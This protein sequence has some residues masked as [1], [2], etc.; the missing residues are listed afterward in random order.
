[1]AGGWWDH[2]AVRD[3]SGSAEDRLDNLLTFQGLL[4]QVARDLGPA[5]ELHP[6]LTTVLNAMRSL[7]K[8]R[9]GTIGLVDERG[10][11]VAAS[12]PPVSPDV[13]AARVPVGSGLAGRCVERGEPVYSPDI[14]VDERVDPELRRVGS[15]RDMRSYL[16]VPLVCLGE[17]IGVLQVDSEEPDAFDA[18]DRRVLEGLAT[19]VAGAIEG[20]RRFE[21]IRR[22]DA[23]RAMFIARVSHELRTPLTILRGF[24]GTL[25]RNAAEYHLNDV[26]VSLVAR[27]DSAG[28]RLQGLVEELL[29]VSRVASGDMAPEPR[30]V[31]LRGELEQ[32]RDESYEPELVTVRC[33]E[34]LVAVV[35]P[36][37]LGH[38]L[39]LLVQNAVAY[40][41]SCELVGFLDLDAGEVEVAVVDH[42]P[43]IPDDRKP[44]VFE[45]FA[46]GD[47]SE[48]GWGLGLSVVAHLVEI[49]GATVVLT[50]T[51]GGGATFSVRLK[52]GAPAAD[53]E[54]HDR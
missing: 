15:N 39:H 51:P 24:T 49:L 47:H 42:G 2:G 34:D 17:V 19:Q 23:A 5:D 1:M 10:V 32:A 9:G 8:F 36:D 6:V 11:Y 3:A 14:D 31:R 54:S 22:L 27:I 30:P 44:L 18:D 28:A 50:D 53:K 46:R 33:E 4:A 16:A 26:A 40:A 45:R 35:D 41:G 12:D 48:P 25:V 29:S 52:Q 21:S 7:V 20:A 43:G 13:A 37:L 38:V